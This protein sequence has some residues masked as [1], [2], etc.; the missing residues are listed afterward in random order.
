MTISDNEFDWLIGLLTQ[1]GS[2]EIMPHFR[3]L[4][5]GEITAKSNAA[6]LVTIADVAAEK[7]ITRELNARFPHA[8]IIGEEAVSEDANVLE[9]HDWEGLTF[10]VDPIDGTFNFASGA[11]IFGTMLAIVK[12]GETIGGIIHDPVMKDTIYA[13]RGEGGFYKQADGKEVK[14]KVSEP[15]SFGQMTGSVSWTGFE[16]RLQA[17][18]VANQTRNLNFFGY[19]CAAHDYRI[20]ATGMAHYLLYSRMMPWDHLAGTL[21]HTEAGGYS[22]RLDTSKYT[23]FTTDGGLLLTS[24][25]DMWEEIRLELWKD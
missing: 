3:R 12:D 19:R 22:A 23:P 2:Q 21:I 15:V 20:L 10:A 17:K 7:F 4:E 24:N 14:L 5:C 16:E 25:K 11:P 9:K 8:T 6:D 13:R 18:I 1:A